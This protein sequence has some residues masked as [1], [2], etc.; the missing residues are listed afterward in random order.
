MILVL[1]SFL[2]VL[3]YRRRRRLT[4]THTHTVHDF[5]SVPD[6]TADGPSCTV[7]GL[8]I[9][10]VFRQCLPLSFVWSIRLG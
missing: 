2:L 3:T 6:R 5:D 4:D 7:H 9:V 8:G 1:A 10:W